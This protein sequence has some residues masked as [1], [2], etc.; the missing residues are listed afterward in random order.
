[1]EAGDR[2][3]GDG[4]EEE[5]KDPRCPG[6]CLIAHSCRGRDDFERLFFRTAAKSENGSH[7]EA[8]R[9]QAEGREQLEG[10]DEIPRLQEHPD[11]QDRGRIR[12]K[13]EDDDP[14]DDR[15]T[16]QRAVEGVQKAPVP[17][18]HAQIHDPQ[19]ED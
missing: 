16:C 10:I 9:H 1:M 17:E 11:R 18:G 12:I 4:D 5:W 7:D 3:A 15:P 2:A 13:Q 14:C 8:D 19:R 6:R